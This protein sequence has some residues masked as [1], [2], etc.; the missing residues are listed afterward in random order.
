MM[1]NS[2]VFN[3]PQIIEKFKAVRIKLIILSFINKFG[4]FFYEKNL[5]NGDNFY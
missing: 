4:G 1:I 5:K 3:F 2:Q